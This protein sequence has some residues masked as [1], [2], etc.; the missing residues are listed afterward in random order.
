LAPGHQP[1]GGGKESTL[2][3]RHNPPAWELRNSG[4]ILIRG[5]PE[6]LVV[7]MACP[8]PSSDFS[9]GS[10]KKVPFHA[11]REPSARKKEE[12]LSLRQAERASH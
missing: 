8:F 5:F 11:R 3:I 6:T 1:E 4:L 10:C 2:N 9:K 12:M 7:S